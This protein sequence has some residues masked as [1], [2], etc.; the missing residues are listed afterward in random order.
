MLTERRSARRTTAPRTT[1]SPSL[2]PRGVPV[3]GHRGGAAGCNFV[4][5]LSTA[6]CVWA[7]SSGASGVHGTRAWCSATSSPPHH[8]NLPYSC[9]FSSRVCHALAGNRRA[10]AQRRTSCRERSTGLSGRK[11]TRPKGR[12]RVGRRRGRPRTPFCAAS[13]AAALS[14]RSRRRRARPAGRPWGRP[15][16][17]E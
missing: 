17:P 6:G 4:R 13:G 8:T 2:A 9:L 15:I 5:P 3:L 12:P 14:R 10:P 11:G 7:R 1:T 16:A